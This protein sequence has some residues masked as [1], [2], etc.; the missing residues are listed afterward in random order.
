MN[1]PHRHIHTFNIAIVEIHSSTNT[2]LKRMEKH[3]NMKED[4]FEMQRN[5]SGTLQFETR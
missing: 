3:E 1:V 5:K 4:H 2:D